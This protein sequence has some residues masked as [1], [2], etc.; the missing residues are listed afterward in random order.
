MHIN[1]FTNMMKEKV[2][3]PI[4]LQITIAINENFK[5]VEIGHKLNALSGD[6]T[7][8]RSQH[9]NN[10]KHLNIDGKELEILCIV[11]S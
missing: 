2:L 6:D 7:V 4:A 8:S 5:P 1:Q 11:V 9:A 10:T 3:H